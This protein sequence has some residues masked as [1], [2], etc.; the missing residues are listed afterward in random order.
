MASTKIFDPTSHV[1]LFNNEVVTGIGSGGFS[2][3]STGDEFTHYYGLGGSYC[4]GYNPERTVILRVNLLQASDFNYKF[5][6]AH[7]NTRISGEFITV[8]V[9]DLMGNSVMVSYYAL[10]NKKPQVTIAG[11]DNENEWEITCLDASRVVG[12]TNDPL[13]LMSIFS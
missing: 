9:V 2:L 1:I 8:K 7:N 11:V 10:L 6:Y 5:S 13:S 3:E 4:A 12:K